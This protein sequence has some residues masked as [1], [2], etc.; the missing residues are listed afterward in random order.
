MRCSR[1]MTIIFKADTDTLVNIKNLLNSGFAN[2]EYSGG[3]NHEEAGD[4]ASGGA[5][6]WLSREAMQIVAESTVMHWSEDVFV[7]LALKE[8]GI[9]PVWNSGYRWKPGEVVDETMIS[10][11]LR[12]ALNAKE[13]DPAWM[14]KYY[15]EMTACNYGY[16]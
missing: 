16:K 7:A 5:G 8:K 15:V 11:H 1:D 6:Y 3:F 10:L 14:Y 9:L 4:F 2:S 13:Y 12:S